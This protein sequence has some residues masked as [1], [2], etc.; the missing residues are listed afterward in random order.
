MFSNK[1]L[2]FLLIAGTTFIKHNANA[3]YKDSQWFRSLSKEKQNALRTLEETLVDYLTPPGWEELV[4]LAPFVDSVVDSVVDLSNPDDFSN[5]FSQEED[6]PSSPNSSSNFDDFSNQFSQEEDAP[7]SPNSSS[8]PYDNNVYNNNTSEDEHP[9]ARI[10]VCLMARVMTLGDLTRL[11]KQEPVSEKTLKNILRHF[12]LDP[13]HNKK[14]KKSYQKLDSDES[15][16]EERAQLYHHQFKLQAK[17]YDLGDIIWNLM[18]VR[19]SA[20]ESFTLVHYTGNPTTLKSECESLVEMVCKLFPEVDSKSTIAELSFLREESW[21]LFSKSMVISQLKDTIIALVNLMI[22]DNGLEDK[23][24]YHTEKFFRVTPLSKREISVLKRKFRTQ[25]EVS[26]TRIV[27]QQMKPICH[28]EFNNGRSAIRALQCL[29]N[30]SKDENGDKKKP[31]YFIWASA[32]CKALKDKHIHLP[33]KIIED[34]DCAKYPNF[35][36]KR[37]FNKYTKDQI[38]TCYESLCNLALLGK[39]QYQDQFLQERRSANKQTIS[40]LFNRWG[41]KF[42]CLIDKQQIEDPVIPQKNK[43]LDQ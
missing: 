2:I 4:E 5:Q 40:D 20:H 37:E 18:E 19:Q 16:E 26:D 27:R 34:F 22:P 24:R 28:H 21:Y 38:L 39:G 12:Q 33:Q 29:V 11:T 42:D 14:S 1:C 6:A 35:Q 13:R 25:T 17:Y 15:S 23:L 9:G 30:S 32:V 36:N 8:N 3:S 31:R 7:F 41:E 43:E 10:I